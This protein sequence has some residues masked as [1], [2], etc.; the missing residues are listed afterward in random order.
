M[1]RAPEWHLKVAGWGFKATKWMLENV[2]DKTDKLVAFK[3]RHRFKNTNFQRLDMVPLVVHAWASLFA[4]TPKNK[5]ALMERGWYHLD[6]RLLR[7]L[8]ILRTKVDTVPPPI[9]DTV[10]SL[11]MEDSTGSIVAH[12]RWYCALAAHRRYIAT[13]RR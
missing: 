4:R 7:D 11:P 12:R 13:H 1:Y 3:H 2:Y 6:K 10:P 8:E 5:D 9:E